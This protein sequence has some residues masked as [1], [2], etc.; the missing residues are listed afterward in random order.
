VKSYSHLDKNFDRMIRG[1]DRKPLPDPRVEEV[2]RGIISEVRRGGD[3]ALVALSNKFSPG[4]VSMK[5]IRL[6]APAQLPPAKVRAV[7]RKGAA[8]VA[9][10]S[11]TRVPKGTMG[12][13][14]QGARVG[15]QYS[16]LQR[17]GIY[18]P[19][20]TAPLVSTA[21]MTVTLAKV[22]GVPEIVVCTPGPVDPTLHY[23][24]QLAGAT[25]IYGVGGAQAVAALAYGTETI[26]PV[27]KVFG[28]G[29]AYVVEAKR[30]VFG[31]IGVD[32]VP[33]PSEIA[34]VADS[35]ADPEF[36]A[37]DL[38]AQAE[39]G[40]GSQ[41]YLLS[42]DRKFIGKVEAALARQLP[43]LSRGDYLRS[44]LDR[45]A[46]LVHTRDLG[47]AVALAE[48]IAPEHLS[49]VCRGAARLARTIRN[50][51]AVFIGGYSPV[52]A[53]DFFAGPSHELPTGG[54][55]KSF[56]GLTVDQFMKR[57]SV[58]EYSRGSLRR[59]AADIAALARLER[60]D[61]HERSVTI[62]LS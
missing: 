13:N 40:P 26:R 31:V 2:V 24:I 46:Y 22:A 34:V 23:A 25:E 8:N 44:T 61:A 53:G 49:L 17:V 42:P 35:T 1:L 9:A 43:T 18:V 57:T 11:R 10:F 33:G 55:A 47:Q 56:P 32:L 38:L 21:L 62:R 20:G 30:Q 59:S 51:G 45:G 14:P 41:I 4:S 15:E 12:R 50:S 6:G 36:V 52:A 39:H 54:G 3:K 5:S 60:L 7:L 27:L 58:V 19:G 28:P 16:P 37:A 48:A 29:N